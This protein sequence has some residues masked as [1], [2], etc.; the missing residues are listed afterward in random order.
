MKETIWKTD[1]VEMYLKFMNNHG[2]KYEY[3]RPFT[4]FIVG[5]DLRFDSW[6]GEGGEVECKGEEGF[7]LIGE[8]FLNELEKVARNYQET[9][10]RLED[11]LQDTDAF[12]LFECLKDKVL[13]SGQLGDSIGSPFVSKFEFEANSNILQNLYEKLKE[14]LIY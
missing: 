1:S 7:N 10:I 11:D 3:P 9:K 6:L 8:Q 2:L 5:I 14:N 12:V 4:S 13:V